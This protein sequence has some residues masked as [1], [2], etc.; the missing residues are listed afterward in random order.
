MFQVPAG[1]SLKARVESW[2][3]KLDWKAGMERARLEKSPN[4][5]VCDG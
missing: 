3:S 1:E 2:N 4:W 5:L